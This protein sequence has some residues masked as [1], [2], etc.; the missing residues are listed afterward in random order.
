MTDEEVQQL[1][2]V[3]AIFR[4]LA[5]EGMALDLTIEAGILGDI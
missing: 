2:I 5:F 3:P 4:T 1:C